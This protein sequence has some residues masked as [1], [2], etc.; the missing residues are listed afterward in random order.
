MRASSRL[1]LQTILLLGSICIL[2]SQENVFTYQ[3]DYDLVL[4]QSLSNSIEIADVNNDGVIDEGDRVF[5][6][7]YIPDFTYGFNVNVGYKGIN[8]S[9]DFYGSQGNDIYNGRDAVRPNR[10]NYETTRNDFWRG[11]GTSSTEPRASQSANNEPS[12]YFV[13]DGSFLRLRNAILSYDIPRQWASAVKISSA[14]VYVKGTNIFTRTDYT[15]YSPEIA[16]NQV[17]A[18]GIDL[19]TYPIVSIYSIGVNLTF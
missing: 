11:E 13:Q 19:G 18:S 3:P 10:F 7:S 1:L 17:D 6:G 8:L 5:I 14:R 9:L 16:S 2:S 12:S 15:G 4:P